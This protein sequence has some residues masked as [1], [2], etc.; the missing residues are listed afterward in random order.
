[1]KDALQQGAM[2]L[3]E[4]T[5]HQLPTD[6]PLNKQPVDSKSYKIDW[7]GTM[8]EVIMRIKIINCMFVS[9]DDTKWPYR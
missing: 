2:F 9:L 4:E 1:M 7:K 3:T 5:H 6:N 8:Q